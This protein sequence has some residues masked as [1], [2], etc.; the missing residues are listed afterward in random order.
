MENYQ[1]PQLVK[2]MHRVSQCNVAIL[3]ELIRIIGLYRFFWRRDFGI[4]LVIGSLFFHIYR[5]CRCQAH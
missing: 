4:V 1:S 5:D 3:I 2:N